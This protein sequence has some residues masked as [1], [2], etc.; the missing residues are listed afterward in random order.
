M[1]LETRTQMEQNYVDEIENLKAS[2]RREK[3]RYESFVNI[4][5]PAQLSDVQKR[6]KNIIHR[7]HNYTFCSCFV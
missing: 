1:K 2:V 5:H 4:E 3:E 6:V 7:I